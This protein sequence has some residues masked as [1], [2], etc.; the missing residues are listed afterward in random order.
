MSEG[1]A[2]E[3]ENQKGEEEKPCFISNHHHHNYNHHQIPRVR[4]LQSGVTQLHHTIF[5]P[6]SSTFMDLDFGDLDASWSFD[7]IPTSPVLI[8]GSDQP[9]SP[10]WAFADGGPAAVNFSDERNLPGIRIPISCMIFF[11]P[12]KNGNFLLLVL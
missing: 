7:Q 9:F 4:E 6:C 8:N 2:V 11:Y 3:E 1:V 10:L 12:S 5:D